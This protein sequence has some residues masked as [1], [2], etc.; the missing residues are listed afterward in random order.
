MRC[1]VGG[2]VP[3]LRRVRASVVMTSTHQYE[4]FLDCRRTANQYARLVMSSPVVGWVV[5]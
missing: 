1:L 3:I 4:H 5:G 2:R